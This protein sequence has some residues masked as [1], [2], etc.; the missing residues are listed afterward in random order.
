M[1][2]VLAALWYVGWPEPPRRLQPSG[3]R[4][5]AA[6][7]NVIESQLAAFRVDDFARAYTFAAAPIQRQFQA[8]DFETMVRRGYPSI[9]DSE[10]ASFGIAL[11][12]GREAVVLV[13]VRGSDHRTARYNYL[14]VREKGVWKITGVVEAPPPA[15]VL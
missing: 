4:V 7:T 10:S 2:L 5:R 3:D 12:N 15:G 9:A 11:D 1:L 14:L 6:L 8:A 13:S